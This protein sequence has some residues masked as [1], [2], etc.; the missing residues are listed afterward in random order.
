MLILMYQCYTQT[1]YVDWCIILY[2]HCLASIRKFIHYA[3]N[4]V[5][6]QHGGVCC[7][8][9]TTLQS[10]HVCRVAYPWRRRASCIMA[11]VGSTVFAKCAED[12]CEC[13]YR[14]CWTQ[15]LFRDIVALDSRPNLIY[16]QWWILTFLA[17]SWAWAP[18]QTTTDIELVDAGFIT[19][20]IACNALSLLNCTK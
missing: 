17:H 9:R 13:L 6:L 18:T 1:V 20:I 12:E 8:D 3:A 5:C 16:I 14:K 10:H 7:F 19:R 2:T 11:K 15:L 4:L